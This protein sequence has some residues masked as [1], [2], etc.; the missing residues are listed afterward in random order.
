MLLPLLLACTGPTIIDREPGVR[1][2]L[3]AACDE[4]DPV[5]CLLPWPS[6]TFTRADPDSAT[7]LRLAVESASLPIADDPSF[8]NLANGFS[9]ITGVAT[10]FEESLDLSRL[11]MT[12]V[13]ASLDPEGPIQL[14]NAQPDSARY[15]QRM[16]MFSEAIDASSLTVERHLLIG[17]PQE[18][19]EANA[20]HVVV[21]L[22]TI[23]SA[24]PR[25]RAVELA[26][27][28]VAPE[29]DAEAAIVGYHAPTRK[30]LDDVG[31]D[32]ARV[33]RVW[34]FT[35]R[36]AEDVT[37]RTHAMMD[38]LNGSLGDL[39]VEID[40][41]VF[42]SYENLAAIVRGRLTNAPNFLDEEGRLVLDEDGLPQVTGTT[43][44]EFR[45]SLPQG[46]PGTPYRVALYGHGTGGDVSDNAFDQEL[47]DYDIAKLNLR[48]DGWT[49]T[50]FILTISSFSAF[51]EG[52]EKS[53]AGLMQ[54][55]AGGTVLL[56]ALDGVL[57]ETLS[58]EVLAG[59][60][61]PVAGRAPLTSDVV[62]VGGSLGGTLGA[63]I[64][65]ADPRLHTAVLN[66][67]GAGWTHMIPHSLLYDAGVG[68]IMLEVYDDILDLQLAFVMSQS[69]W[70]DVD[71]A[72][73]AE[74]ALA[75][76]GNFLMQQS[77][78][79]PVLPAVGTNLLSQALGARQFEPYLEPVYGLSTVDGAVN[80][81]AVLEQFRVPDTGVY[82]VHGFAAR[83][84]IAGQAALAQILE[85]L[86]SH[87]SGSVTVSHPTI[88]VEQGINGTCDFSDAWEEEE[89]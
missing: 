18:V 49:S 62:W 22:D 44:I 34:D 1:A 40:S 26:L 27:G 10:A 74:E 6:N 66:V 7:G 30:L 83:D 64:I 4:A 88:C 29:D 2:P 24:A 81:G 78:G 55:I 53:T 43:S 54:S 9:R 48:F 17:R 63:V 80:S 33:V 82:D 58:A 59:E 42:P 75:A 76:G 89:E 85:L 45:I 21:V 65:S 8:L 12:D 46:D 41:A 35:T 87:W 13:S 32:P 37:Y 56:S 31:I 19:L 20:D 38:V 39:G 28:L 36:S 50:D 60:P 11:S 16:G 3:T 52:S 70:D 23:G 51:L 69:S 15:G 47:S 71:G 86:D 5:R 25:P 79:D 57:G 84:T 68:G 73:W 61:N 67:P 72:V 77:M 14:F